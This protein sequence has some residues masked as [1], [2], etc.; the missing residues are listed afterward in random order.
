MSHGLNR[1]SQRKVENILNYMKKYKSKFV[2]STKQVL[3][4]K[5]I[6]SS[7]YI[8]TEVIYEKNTLNFH[9]KELGEKG[10]KN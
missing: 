2:D 10:E 3:K 7:I 1:K 5:F 4:E 6:V 9:L 8:R